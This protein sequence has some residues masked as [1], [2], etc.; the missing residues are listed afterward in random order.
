MKTLSHYSGEAFHLGFIVHAVSVNERPGEKEGKKGFLA[1]LTT[2]TITEQ[3]QNTTSG[4]KDRLFFM[5]FRKL[6]GLIMINYF[7]CLVC[8]LQ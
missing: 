6:A 1:E 4:Y 3:A 2:I 5:K 7:W 8:K